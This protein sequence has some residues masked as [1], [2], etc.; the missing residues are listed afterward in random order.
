MAVKIAVLVPNE[1]H[2]IPPAYDNH[3]MFAIHLGRFEAQHPGEFE[4]YW[5]TVGRVLTPLARERLTEWA[6][7]EGMDYMLMIDDDMLLPMDMFEKLYAT[8][9]ETNADIVCPLAFTRVAPHNPVIYRIREGYDHVAHKPYFDR[10]VVKNYPKD[11]VVECDAAG[12]GSALIRLSMVRK[13]K[14]PYFMSTTGAGEDILFCRN[15][16]QEAKA[17]IVVDT[18]IKL[19]HLGN[20]P[21]ITEETYE[22]YNKIADLRKVLGDAPKELVANAS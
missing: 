17:K 22:E 7:E 20:P 3:M 6:L 5:G 15:A 9:Q 10:E 4:I 19:G 8:M 12:F 11:T 16:K 14:K 2:T 21:V 18:R 13:L 1:G